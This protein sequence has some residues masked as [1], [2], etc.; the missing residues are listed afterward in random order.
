MLFNHISHQTILFIFNFS[1]FP[2]KHLLLFPFF[3]PFFFRFCQRRRKKEKAWPTFVYA[4]C[5]PIITVGQD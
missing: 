3:F 2:H 4:S 5:C 1:A